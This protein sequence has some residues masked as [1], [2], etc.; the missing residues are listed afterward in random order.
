MRVFTEQF[1]KPSAARSA[2]EDPQGTAELEALDALVDAFALA[3]KRKLR[4]AALDKGR[5]GWDDPSW[6]FDAMRSSLF[7]HLCKGDPIDVANFAAFLWNRDGS[8]APEETRAE[9]EAGRESFSLCACCQALRPLHFELRDIPVAGTDITL[10]GIL[11]G[12]CDHCDTVVTIPSESIVD[13]KA[14]LQ[15]A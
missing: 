4:R 14:Q 9:A 13:V 7:S 6:S 10:R 12:V 11:A 8:T 1:L 5:S 2:G 3:M 15:A